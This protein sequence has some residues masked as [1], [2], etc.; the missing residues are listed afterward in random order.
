MAD[1]QTRN[2]ST[3]HED[4]RLKHC[5]SSCF[6]QWEAIIGYSRGVPID[7]EFQSWLFNSSPLTRGTRTR[8]W[9]GLHGLLKLRGQTQQ[10]QTAKYKSLERSLARFLECH[11]AVQSARRDLLDAFETVRD[12]TCDP[13]ETLPKL[14]QWCLLACPSGVCTSKYMRSGMSSPLG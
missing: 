7:R 4:S 10:M 1:I 5:L 6:G 3:A 11:D 9:T 8:I 2:D 14:E 13:T 12:S